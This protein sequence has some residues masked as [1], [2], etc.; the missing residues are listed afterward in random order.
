MF[1]LVLS[2]S[3][4]EQRSVNGI[5]VR[6]RQDVNKYCKQNSRNELI[7]FLT[8]QWKIGSIVDKQ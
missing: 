6:I 7:T 2:L 5:K 8:F 1:N 3:V 4:K